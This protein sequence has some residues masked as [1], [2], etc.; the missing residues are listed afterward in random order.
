[1]RQI[2][3]RGQW[4]TQEDSLLTTTLSISI[5][6]FNFNTPLTPMDRSSRQ[7]I[8]KETQALKD[9]M[10]QMDLIHIYRTFHPKTVDFTFFS[11]SHRIFS[12]IDHILG[13]K[14]S[15]GKFFKK[16]IL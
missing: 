7:K 13:H 9:T 5:S 16:L 1:M 2:G 10:N 12:R 8:S 4:R 14:L 6:F 15:H 11:N 3:W